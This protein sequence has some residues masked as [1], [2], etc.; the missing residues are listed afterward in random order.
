[1]GSSIRIDSRGKSVLRVLPRLNDEV[2][3]EWIND[4][5]RFAI[6]GLSKQRLDRPYIKNETNLKSTD[7]N[8]ALT[9]VVEEITKRGLK[10][11]VALSGKFTDIET[12]YAAKS[13]LNSIDSDFYDCRFD[14]AQFIE[15]QRSSYIFN[16][17]IQE[18][19]NADAI[20][21]VGS[22]PRWEASVLNARIRKAYIN[23]DCKIGLIG[24]KT[25][26]TY[27]YH[28]LSDDISYLNDILK[29]TS[30]YSEILNN[31]KKPMIIIGTSAIN[32][33]DGHLIIKL[34]EE[35]LSKYSIDNDKYSGLNILQ[36]NISRVGALDLG[37]YNNIFNNSLESGL[38]KH[39]SKNKPVVFLLGL[40]DIDFSTLKGSFVVYIGHHGDSGA[41]IA[42]VVLPAP[43][44][45]ERTSTFVNMEG[46]VLQTTKC[47]NPIG[48][49]KEEWKIFRSLSDKFSSNIKFDNLTDLRKEIITKFTFLQQLNILPII[50]KTKFPSSLEI[51]KRKIKYN[52]SNFY[53]TDSI[54]RA[55]ETMANCTKEI[56]DKVKLNKV[57]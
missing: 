4:K 52:I 18:I 54:S 49:S 16:S 46:R 42:D 56:L 48:E 27:N 7:W 11:T 41:H 29:G 23:N 38:Q 43:A 5:S 20:L 35:I 45:S 15:K 50:T 19:D 32:F 57:A 25:D 55:S 44:F 33:E 10:S 34:C 24:P 12:L 30:Q 47:F 8:T 3:E 2:N 31:A 13:F 39:V 14:N 36:Q 22:N 9:K 51:K 1:M 37:F 53:M 21:L 17:S 26:L 28:H 6:D 40:D